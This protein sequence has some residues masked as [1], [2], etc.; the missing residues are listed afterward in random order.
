MTA[1][2]L[3][4]LRRALRPSRGQA[5]VA[6][7]LALVGFG[8]VVQAR[9]AT[10]S[11]LAG[12]RQPELV[13]ILDDTEARSQQ[14]RQEQAR[15]QAQLD[16]LRAAGADQQ[17]AAAQARSRAEQLEVLAGTRA[18]RGPGVELRVPDPHG[19]VGAAT[20]L[21]A[22]QELRDAGA[23]VVAVDG[24]R[25]VASS[26]FVDVGGGVEV[27]WTG[28]SAEVSAP[29]LLQAIGPVQEL[30]TGLAIPGGVLDD[31]QALQLEPVLTSA[32]A[33]ELGPLPGTSLPPSPLPSGSPGH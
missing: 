6:V 19:A 3:E 1:P 29:Y 14:L 30:R 27:R 18:A 24:V 33:L 13:R 5:V 31:L 11:G 4:L 20:L 16:R 22:V 15:L 17:A 8:L 32:G 28:G 12:L 10:G 7:L 9:S 23:E 26:A 25:I 2:A 21:D